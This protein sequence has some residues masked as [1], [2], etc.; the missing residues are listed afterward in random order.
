MLSCI[1][2]MLSRQSVDM[3]LSDE[4]RKMAVVFKDQFAITYEICTEQLN[5]VAT[6]MTE[7]D[8]CVRSDMKSGSNGVV[9]IY[10]DQVKISAFNTLGP[11]MKEMKEKVAGFVPFVPFSISTHTSS[12]T[13]AIDISVSIAIIY[14][15]LY[16]FLEYTICVIAW[17]ILV[18][19][20]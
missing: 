2:T 15:H 7:L 4:L 12:A 19:A 6:H 3:N 9:D 18:I 14:S 11:F 16:V 8:C 20:D 13:G 17:L 1:Q 5:N 10:V